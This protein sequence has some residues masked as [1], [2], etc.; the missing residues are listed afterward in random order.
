MVFS[1]GE[2]S[3][4]EQ[5]IVLIHAYQECADCA[6]GRLDLVLSCPPAAHTRPPASR[7]GTDGIAPLVPPRRGKMPIAVL[8][9]Q[10]ATV[11]RKGL[12]DWLY[13]MFTGD[14][15]KQHVFESIQSL[16]ELHA[17][18]TLRHVYKGRL[19]V[20]EVSFQVRV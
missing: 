12:A 10:A 5:A 17:Q 19:P 18:N 2:E 15:D 6:H 16:A 1:D 4:Q 11:M 8:H 13:T 20:Y 3:V 9:K 7:C 14:V